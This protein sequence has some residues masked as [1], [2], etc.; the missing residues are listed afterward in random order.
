MS[1][2]VDCEYDYLVHPPAQ[3]LSILWHLLLAE[4]RY[5]SDIT[6]AQCIW[7]CVSACVCCETVHKQT[8]RSCKVLKLIQKLVLGNIYRPFAW[9]LYAYTH[10]HA[11]MH[12]FTHVQTQVKLTVAI[13]CVYFVYFPL[14]MNSSKL[15][16]T[17]SLL[18]AI[19]PPRNLWVSAMCTLSSALCLSLPS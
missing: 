8:E 19:S 13:L 7:T 1:H 6:R 18:E 9:C 5:K 2:V 11:L 15:P 4:L 14:S 17:W 12:A 16:W 10:L 3:C